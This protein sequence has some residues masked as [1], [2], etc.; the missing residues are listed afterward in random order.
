[1]TKPPTALDGTKDTMHYGVAVKAQ[2]RGWR[3]SDT[4]TPDTVLGHNR[5]QL[6]RFTCMHSVTS[7]ITTVPHEA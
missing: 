7:F 5:K 6:V 2:E 1:M 3:G 4:K